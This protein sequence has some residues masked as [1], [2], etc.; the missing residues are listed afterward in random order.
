MKNVKRWLAVLM[1]A[2]MTV[3]MCA[4][5]SGGET[6]NTAE[7]QPAADKTQAADDKDIPTIKYSYITFNNMSEEVESIEEAINAYT[8]EKIGVKVDLVQY[9]IASY[10]E[11]MNMQ[12]SS[13][14]DVGLFVPL[15]YASAV[16]K[17][18]VMDIGELLDTCAP[19]TKALVGEEWLK[20]TSTKGVVYAV[21]AYK[22]VALQ[23]YVLMR[24][25]IV[26]EL[27]I[28]VSAIHKIQD[29]ESVYEKVHAAYPD[30]YCLAPLNANNYYAQDCFS[31]AT[32]GY[33]IDNLG[34]RRNTS[35]GALVGKDSGEVVNYYQTDSFKDTCSLMYNWNQKGYLMPETSV[36]PEMCS[37]IFAALTE[38]FLPLVSGAIQRTAPLPCT[39]PP[40]NW[41]QPIL[42]FLI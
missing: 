31:G 14:E 40:M 10:Q 41:W 24:K 21:P 1:A 15:D 8:A 9:D 18:Q 12:I 36:S 25:D 26:E 4:C 2:S 33:Y 35:I 3:G 37:W 34:G 22:G 7:N 30:M 19:E 17:G 16:S 27:G 38:H 5:G 28:D 39:A 6:S 11:Q 29:L 20:A 23:T 42:R 13:G 32:S